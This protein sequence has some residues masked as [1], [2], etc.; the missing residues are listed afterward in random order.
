MVIWFDK[1]SQAPSDRY[2]DI[3]TMTTST[4]SLWLETLGS[5]F[6]QYVP[7][8]EAAGVNGVLLP[9]LTV[10]DLMAMGVE[11]EIHRKKILVQRDV[12]IEQGFNKAL[13]QQMHSD[14]LARGDGLSSA[15]QHPE[16]QRFADRALAAMR[17]AGMLLGFSETA[18]VKDLD[19]LLCELQ[20]EGLNMEALE[21]V[22]HFVCSQTT[23]VDQAVRCVREEAQADLRQ[24]VQVRSKHCQ[25]LIATHEHTKQLAVMQDAYFQLTKKD[26]PDSEK[27]QQRAQFRQSLQ[28]WV[29][30]MREL[31]ENATGCHAGLLDRATARLQ[32]RLPG[33]AAVEAN[34]QEFAKL[35]EEKEKAAE[36]CTRIY[37]LADRDVQLA[38]EARKEGNL[39]QR[40]KHEEEQLRRFEEQ[41]DNLN[42]QIREKQNSK[43]ELRACSAQQ[44]MQPR[45]FVTGTSGAFGEEIG[46]QS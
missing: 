37:N 33:G 30:K 5:H 9:N 40:M 2:Q 35:T 41:E 23:H 17:K 31:A 43:R 8:F 3:G 1:K 29:A 4:V 26:M 13:H 20:E 36:K 28:A 18:F 15:K 14:R 32:S 42:K 45:K 34:I 25:R 22:N 39:L 24:I 11:E 46:N 19:D 21:V 44:Q 12:L 10:D 7:R 38:L 16:P 27:E 6:E